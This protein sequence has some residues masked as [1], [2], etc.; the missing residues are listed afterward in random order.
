MG[1]SRRLH[2]QYY[3]ESA[4]KL[5]INYEYRVGSETVVGCCWERDKPNMLLA[6]VMDEFP[7]SRSGQLRGICKHIAKGFNISDIVCTRVSRI[8][9][10][11]TCVHC[12]YGRGI[13]LTSGFC[14]MS[15]KRLP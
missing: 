9:P 7:I 15:P 14:G 6:V 8:L 1:L 3:G 5:H 13:V 12:S 4:V 11:E 2:L 10:R